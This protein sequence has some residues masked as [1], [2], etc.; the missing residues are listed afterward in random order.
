MNLTIMGNRRAKV[1]HRRLKLYVPFHPPHHKTSLLM[2]TG[3]E[4]QGDLLPKEA[5]FGGWSV[6]KAV[7]ACAS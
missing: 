7:A 6:L 3:G 5:P 2:D 1:G 4:R